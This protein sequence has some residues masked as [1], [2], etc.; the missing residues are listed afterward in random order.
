MGRVTVTTTIKTTIEVP[1][2]LTLE[3]LQDQFN[4][5]IAHLEDEIERVYNH[6]EWAVE[7]AYTGKSVDAC[8]WSTEHKITEE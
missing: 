2:G 6:Q 4:Q 3:M 1:E 8:R 5:N 7:Q